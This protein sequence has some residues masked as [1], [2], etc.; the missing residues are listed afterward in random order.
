M[1]VSRR[2]IG[3]AALA[4]GVLPHKGRAQAGPTIRIGVLTDMSGPYRDTGGPTSVACARQ[5]VV[6]FGAAAR[7]LNVEVLVADH[8]N[9]PDVGVN[10]ARQW[11]DREGV[12]MVCEIN[13]SAIALAVNTVAQDKNKAHVNTGAAS[14]D[15]TGP[16]CSPNMVHWGTDTWCQSHTVGGAL[17]KQGAKR[18]FFLAADYTFGHVLMRE[19]RKVVQEA[20]GETVGSVAYPF[21]NT[22]DFSSFLLTAQSARPDVI[23]LCN[24]ASD[25]VNCVKQAREFGLAS[26]GIRIT[27]LVGFLTDVKSLGLEVGQGL[28]VNEPFYWDLNPRTRGLLERV[29]PNA[30][31]NW[32]NSQHAQCY[33]GVF[34][35]LRAVHELGAARAKASGRDTIAMMKRMPTDDDALGRGSVREDGRKIHPSYLF[36]VKAPA[37]S[38][39]P[40]DLYKLAETTPAE[41]AFRPL[42]EGACPLVRN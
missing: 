33:S 5:A 31:N 4:A 22:T 28:L 19:A 27:A 41:A 25:T 8:Q 32:P 14:A 11:F 24:A 30:P 42:A 10:V 15:L 38:S 7:G 3:G 40:W 34:H 35:Y 36:Q 13:N 26:R 1:Q 12:D 39:G 21:P 6:D 23:A 20:G 17:M 18:W 16:A 37:E 29:R 2:T 9:R